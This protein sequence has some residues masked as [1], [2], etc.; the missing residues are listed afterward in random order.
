MNGIEQPGEELTSPNFRIN[1]KK[2]GRE[3]LKGYGCRDR[4]P[5]KHY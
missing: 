5:Q 3:S 1:K 4:G 2:R